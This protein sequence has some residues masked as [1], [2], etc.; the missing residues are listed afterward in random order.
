MLDFDTYMTPLRINW[1]RCRVCGGWTTGRVDIGVGATRQYEFLCYYAGKSC[2]K[3]FR[4]ILHSKS[5]RSLMDR[6]LITNQDR[7]RFESSRVFQL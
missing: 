5:T 3:W 4:D 2:F 1:G 6:H 7:W